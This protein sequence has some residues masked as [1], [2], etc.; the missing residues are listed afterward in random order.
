M[1]T[2]EE[3]DHDLVEYILAHTN[4]VLDGKQHRQME[5]ELRQYIYDAEKR[6]MK[7][8]IDKQPHRKW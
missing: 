2:D 8:W 7:E 4:I 6:A 3:I 5:I 1:L